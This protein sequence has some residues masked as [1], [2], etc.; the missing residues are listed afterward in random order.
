MTQPKSFYVSIVILHD[1]E[2]WVA[3]CLEYD[4]TAQGT[5][6]KKAMKAF[7]KTFI[8]QII[9]DIK[10]DKEPLQGIP[11]APAEYWDKFEEGE[12]LADRKPFRV[13]EGVPPGFIIAAAEQLRICA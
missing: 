11:Q 13:P 3:Q 5:S 4:V 12:R 10:A 7:E 1:G 9:L 6:M 8:G 2:A